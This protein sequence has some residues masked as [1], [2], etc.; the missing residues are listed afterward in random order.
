MQPRLK[1]SDIS[2][3]PSEYL[4]VAKESFFIRY[5]SDTDVWTHEPELSH[6]PAI[7]I[8]SL[9]MS[10]PHTLDLGAGK[11][12]DVEVF[13]RAG[14][15]VTAVDLF[16][17]DSWRELQNRWRGNVN[18]VASPFLDWSPAIQFDAI[19]D[20]GCFHHQHPSEYARHLSHMKAMMKP[21]AKAAFC[22]FTPNELDRKEGYF[23]QI[24]L[25]RI[26]R[27][28]TEAELKQLLEAS[29]FRWLRSKRVYREKYDRYYLVAL[30]E[31]VE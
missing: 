29:G 26:S 28:F 2:L 15:R 19:L 3:S 11:G 7:L 13:L 14:H 12:R 22:V 24:D 27:Y 23:T 30:V 4:A 18:F 1:T 17:Q 31:N 16:N 6:A 21:R 25:G 20:N 8:E 5:E 9:P 10:Q